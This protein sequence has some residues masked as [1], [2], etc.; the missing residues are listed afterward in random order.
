MNQVP[1]EEAPLRASDYKPSEHT[2]DHVTFKLIV[3]SAADVTSQVDFCLRNSAEP[4]G[5]DQTPIKDFSLD[6]DKNL[7]VKDVTINGT[8]LAADC[9][10]IE[11]DKLIVSLP[12]S[13]PNPNIS[14]TS[15]L[16]PQ[17]VTTGEGLYPAGEAL[18][19]QCESIN[20]RQMAPMFDR[21]DVM[22]KWTYV[23]DAPTQEFPTVLAG[24]TLESCTEKDSKKVYVYQNETPT[25][26]YLTA[27]ALGKYSKIED[28]FL[29]KD[30]RTIKLEVYVEPGKEGM[31]K[32]PM[33]VLKDAM[34]WDEERFGFTT[35]AQEYR[36]VVSPNFNA[37]AMENRRLNIFNERYAFFD[38]R[39]HTDEDARNV[40]TVVSHEFF[41]DKTGND[42]TLRDWFEIVL[43][44]GLTVFREQKF[45]EETGD[46]TTAA[47]SR[48]RFLQDKM[49]PKD[50]A[51][52]S[53]PLLP[54]EVGKLDTLYDALR[55]EKGA[56]VVRMI[57]TMIG[58]DLFVEALKEY[59]H[60]FN[61]Q[62]VTVNDFIDVMAEVGK[63]DLKQFR[64]TWYEQEGVAECGVTTEYDPVKKTFTMNVTQK[65]AKEG[66][67]PYHFPLN[68]AL[69]SQD[70][71]TIPLKLAAQV[72]SHEHDLKRGMLHVTEETQTF[73]FTD[74][75]SEPVPSVMRNY[76]APVRL[77]MEQSRTEAQFLMK[78]ETDPVNRFLA[79]QKAVVGEITRSIEEGVD[80]S[81]EIFGDIIKLIETDPSMAA[82]LMVPPSI[83][84]IVQSMPT[85]DYEAARKARA[86]MMRLVATQFES[87][88]RYFC[89]EVNQE[90][91]YDKPGDDSTYKTDGRSCARR[92]LYNS[93]CTYLMTLGKT[94]DTKESLNML[95]FGDN[96][97]FKQAALG[98]VANSENLELRGNFLKQEYEK[99]KKDP[100]LFQKWLTVLAGSDCDSVID[101]VRAA[102]TLPEYDRTV[103][104]NTYSLILKFASNPRM[105]DSSGKGYELLA[106]EIITMNSLNGSVAA[107]LSDEFKVYPKLP[108][109]LQSVMLP[110]LQRILA[111]PNLDK[112][113]SE[114]IKPLFSL[115]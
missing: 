114:H 32:L 92:K 29:T 104:N 4:T 6:C 109:H 16:N 99:S 58:D 105:H 44:E 8:V 30:G 47:I 101:D 81:V 26:C 23:I 84:V 12:D 75:Q 15:Q 59:I 37:G 50:D 51:P 35:S 20:F 66:Q 70:G 79:C 62:A 17:S 87:Y 24:G 53:M 97:T 18:I 41:H 9:W 45:M 115:S 63:I 48:L 65:P 55:Y 21:P 98:R 96:M 34:A 33:K 69:F 108:P 13:L 111:T 74:V 107:R 54:Q 27:V 71:T 52:T 1:V 80:P 90:S 89:D 46:P 73:V 102:L 85:A 95:E 14:I 38:P 68:V 22:P 94:Q 40:G 72:G 11:N 43:K 57:Y 3:Q 78:H 28:E 42:V 113:V 10:R 76:S 77:K 67:K 61:G 31:G 91:Q 112:G 60:R 2:T 7:A 56:E 86:K 64:E 49:F 19:T 82:E 39:V 5:T 103:A 110:H 36:I 100:I 25:P 88:F 106:D 93:A 83:E